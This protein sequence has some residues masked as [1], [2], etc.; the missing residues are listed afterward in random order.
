MENIPDFEVDYLTEEHIPDFD[1]PLIMPQLNRPVPTPQPSVYNMDFQEPLSLIPLTAN[2]DTNLPSF[3]DNLFLDLKQTSHYAQLGQVLEKG[4]RLLRENVPA[5]QADD[6]FTE[7][8]TESE[9]HF[10]PFTERLDDTE[11]P[12]TSCPTVQFV[13]PKWTL[14]NVMLYISENKLDLN[15]YMP[16][17]VGGSH[18]DARPSAP[19]QVRQGERQFAPAVPGVQAAPANGAIAEIAYQE[20]RDALP[21]LAERGPY[22]AIVTGQP[23]A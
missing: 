20:P 16:R 11:Q 9:E 19:Y 5:L 8:V 15:K 10:R 3:A 7:F 12:T 17:Q 23:I 1:D 14:E 6:R 4:F 18:F 2:Q 22:E 21:H 13:E